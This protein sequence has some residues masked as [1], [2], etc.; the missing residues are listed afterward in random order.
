VEEI[1][2]FAH[3]NQMAIRRF[4]LEDI[5]IG[6]VSIPKG[7]TVM[8]CLASANRDPARYPDADQFDV[9][10]ADKGHLVLGHGLHFCL[11]ASLARI[12][13]QVGLA[14]LLRRFPELRLA[15]APDKLKWRPS[16]RSHALQTLPV[17]LG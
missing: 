1:F 16:W 13:I 14:T 6:G 10:R 15:V 4:P 5:E 7:D 9:H 11:G 8:L 12:E 2:R 3:P 17:T